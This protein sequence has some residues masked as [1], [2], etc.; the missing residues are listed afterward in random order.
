MNDIKKILIASICV[1]LAVAIAAGVS[2]GVLAGTVNGLKDT[3]AELRQA[4]EAQEALNASMQAELDA[5][6]AN[7]ENIVTAE[8]FE[9]KLAEA[10]GTQT[11]TMQSM[12][13]TAVKNQIEELGVEGLTEAQV[14][15][16][17]D[18]A[19][20]NC[21]TEDD[22][23]AIIADVDAGL[24]KDEVKKIITDYT[25]G[26][27]TYG[28]IMNLIEDETYDLRAFLEAQINGLGNTVADK[29]TKLTLNATDYSDTCTLTATQLDKLLSGGKI[30][31]KGD[32]SAKTLYINYIGEKDFVID[33]TAITALKTL[34]I[35]AP[36]CHFEVLGVGVTIENVYATVAPDSLIF[37]GAFNI[38]TVKVD[39][40][41]VV[42]GEDTTVE[43]VNI[44]GSDV[45]LENKGEIENVTIN[46]EG[47][48]ITNDT[49]SNPYA[50]IG[51][52]YVDEDVDR[53]EIDMDEEL[54]DK[55]TLVW[56]GESV[57]APAY[58]EDAKTYTITDARELAWI[59]TAGKTFEG[60]TIELTVNIDLDGH[61]WT[62]VGTKE[63]P[64]KGT[65]DGQG[66]TIFNL[67]INAEYASM[68][69]YVVDG[70]IE[71]VNFENVNI[72]GKHIAVVVGYAKNATLENIHVISGAIEATG[73]GA[74]IICGF[75]AEL[76]GEA[77]TI[78]NCQNDV[79][80]NAGSSASGIG[81]WIIGKSTVS[82]CVNNGII[83]G[84]GRAAGICGNFVGTM[85]DCENNGD[86][87]S[88]GSG[89]AGGMVAIASGAI[90][91]TD[92]VNNGNVTTTVDNINA[93]AAGI[94]GQ[95]PNAKIAITNCV[96][97]GD[98]TAEK[99]M[100]AGIG[101]S[102]YGGI[103]ATDCKNKG[104]ITYGVEKGSAEIVAEKPYYGNGNNTVVVTEPEV[105]PE[106]TTATPTEVATEN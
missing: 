20:A 50:T 30:V 71:N 49:E 45:K 68:F 48:T 29:T 106:A 42:V 95:T 103:T 65:F 67:T 98:I 52:I 2:I 97:T 31:L 82:G 60:E 83:I 10:L 35:I 54:A 21:L 41:R 44:E 25:A 75:E 90:T 33:L 87:T 40:G 89:A 14:N 39:K 104:K 5:A 6:K 24:T 85:T 63:V 37:N 58:D 23:D 66:Y 72:A 43:N 32:W 34:D 84:G 73:Y 56:D 76:D 4:N 79:D 3:V 16:I 96:N 100:A 19:V 55:I 9:S 12:I 91:F 62:P 11:Q 77:I 36:K 61:A 102:L 94:L 26:Y 17:I 8:E 105:E 59:A 99:S 53:D 1:V 86:V 18:A 13:A 38:G 22:I 80:I 69:A 27:L 74:G 70:V 78:K 88:N 28:Q 81:A 7:G 92:C 93:S 57:K 51:N 15:E 47:A 64:F 101:V 46:S